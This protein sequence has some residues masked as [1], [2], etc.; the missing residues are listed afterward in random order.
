MRPAQPA[1]LLRIHLSERDRF[2]GKPLFE[3]IV[4]R[5]RKLGIAGATVLRGIEG[6]GESAGLHQSG[7]ERP[8]LITI[9]DEA[10]NIER[11]LPEI[12]PMLDTAVMALSE[13]RAVRIE[14]GAS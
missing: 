11:L 2:D 10:A 13:V 5:C 4:E 1:R 12:E 8:L 7:D 14:S 6:Y 3:A 9:V